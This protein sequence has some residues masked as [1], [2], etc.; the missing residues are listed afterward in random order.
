V[1]FNSLLCF[2]I[3]NTDKKKSSSIA[4]N[5][6]VLIYYHTATGNTGWLTGEI[7]HQL[8]EQG[9]DVTLRNIAHQR[10]T[11]DAGSYDLTGFG[12]PVMGFRPTFS[13]TDFIDKL[14][15]QQG[16]AAFIY[17]TCA[18]L[19]ASSLWILSQLLGEKG[20]GVIAAEQFRGEVSWPVARVPGII[21][22]KGR[23]DGR[24]LQAI[25]QVSACLYDAVKRRVEKGP[26]A[27]FAVPFAFF[28]PFSYLGRTNKA[29]YLRSIMGTKKVD[30]SRCTRCG[31]CEKYCGS[32]AIVLDPWPVFSDACC[33]CW[34]CYSI[35]PEEA[36]TTFLGTRGRYATRSAY[37][38]A[39]ATGNENS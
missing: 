12:C 24:D 32:R 14:P 3:I 5:F 33:G 34:G 36:I 25:M 17:V 1:F 6:R 21:P 26:A 29:A 8:R 4:M 11:S 31:L 15:A 39:A 2:S 18:G 35:C 7:A 23:P 30:Q 22:D 37:L 13:M 38:D 27:P 28:N 19:C 10:D 20:Y 9:C 16:K